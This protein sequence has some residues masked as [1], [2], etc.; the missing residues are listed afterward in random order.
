MN[1]SRVVHGAE[2]IAP[3]FL[4]PAQIQNSK[5]KMYKGQSGCIGVNIMLLI[6]INTMVSAPVWADWPFYIFWHEDF[7]H[8]NSCRHTHIDSGRGWQILCIQIWKLV[9]YPYNFVSTLNQR[10]WH[11]VVC[12]V[13][14]NPIQT[15]YQVGQ[16]QREAESIDS[17]DNPVNTKHR[18]NVGLML[19]QTMVNI[20]SALGRCLVFAGRLDQYVSIGQSWYIYHQYQKC[21]K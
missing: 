19:S 13:D 17:P 16:S 5:R 7:K 9:H 2:I 10:H 18:P 4:Q 21:I 14:K 15:E 11:S 1:V 3:D 8:H 20:I 6:L 12:P